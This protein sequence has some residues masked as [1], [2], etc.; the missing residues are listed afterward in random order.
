[1]QSIDLHAV[2]S[3][4]ASLKRLGAVVAEVDAELRYVWV[5]NPHPDFEASSVV[6]SGTTG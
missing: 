2:A 4:R 5:D 1:M 3:L 6:A